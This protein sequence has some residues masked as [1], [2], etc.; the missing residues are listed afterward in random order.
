MRLVGFQDHLMK[1]PA[2]VE[3]PVNNKASPNDT[4]FTYQINGYQDFHKAPPEYLRNHFLSFSTDWKY[5]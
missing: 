5:L 2:A 1:L 4:G 3:E